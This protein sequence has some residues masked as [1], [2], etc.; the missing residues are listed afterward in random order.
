MRIL[1]LLLLLFALLLFTLL[2]PPAETT[3]VRDPATSPPDLRVRPVDTEP[4]T[5]D[6]PRI[7]QRPLFEPQRRPVRTPPREEP[8]P[9]P[10]RVRLSAVTVSSDLRVAV[11]RDLD[12]GNTRRVREGEKLN[13]WTI[14][15]VHSDQ[16][17]L[18][19]RD[20]EITIPLL[21]GE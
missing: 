6:L 20:K 11:I 19:W 12:S 1:G 13:D 17:V 10:P 7:V 3:I 8:A 14:K 9:E 2:R 21:S 18:Q 15:R 5:A 16:I 4:S